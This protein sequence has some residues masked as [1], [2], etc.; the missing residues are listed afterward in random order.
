MR[1]LLIKFCFREKCKNV[2]V[3]FREVDG[4][5]GNRTRILQKQT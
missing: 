1:V 3:I 4:Y 2:F 5:F